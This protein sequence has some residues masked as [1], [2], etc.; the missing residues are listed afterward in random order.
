MEIVFNIGP[1]PAHRFD[2]TVHTADGPAERQPQTLKT[3][4]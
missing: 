2:V 3:G 4:R 1:A